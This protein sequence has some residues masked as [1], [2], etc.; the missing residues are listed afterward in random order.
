MVVEPS[1]IITQ[2]NIEVWLG[3]VAHLLSD[4]GANMPNF[5]VVIDCMGDS[6]RRDLPKRFTQH[7]TF[8]EVPWNY[9]PG[10]HDACA[11]MLRVVSDRLETEV[12]TRVLV[13]CK[14]GERRSAA[15]LAVLLS[16]LFDMEVDA[17]CEQITAR[18]PCARVTTE[19]E[20]WYPA[21]L[22][23]VRRVVEELRRER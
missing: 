10:R 23:E 14:K 12:Y 2:G 1:C 15:V 8:L 13:F 19:P 18:R 3:S 22:P 6:P 21:A 7:V 5:D 11:K 20:G 17:A 16:V 9:G 4:D